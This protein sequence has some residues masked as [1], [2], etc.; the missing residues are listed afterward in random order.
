MELK[1]K[2]VGCLYRVSTKKQV[3]IEDDIPMQRNACM[4]FIKKREDWK[5]N[6]E[7]VEP[8][9]SG[10]HKGLNE[11]KVLQEVIKDVGE[12]NIDVLLV[13][14]FDRLGRKDDETPFLLKRIVE[15]GVEVWSVCEGQQT[16]ENSSDNLM[17][18]IRFWGASTESKKTAARVDSGRNY[19]TKMG[20]FT[21]G[22]VPYGYKLVPTGELDRK[23]RM[24]NKFAKDE[25][26]SRVVQ[27]MYNKLIDENMTLNGIVAYLNNDRHLKTR[28]GNQ[29]NTSTVRG[30]LKNPIYKGYMSYGK[31][32]MKEVEKSRNIDI[33]KEDFLD[34]KKR[35]RAVPPEEWILA[36]KANTD[37]VIVSEERWQLAQ[38]ILARRYKGYTDNLRTVED[39]T[40]K[41]SLL[42]V[43]LL[44]CGYCHGR[45]SPAVS[46][47]K[48][49]KVDGT[50]SRSYTEFYKCNV[51]G[52]SKKMCPSKS[53][54]SKYKLESA[55]LQEV[56]SFLDRVEQ[57]DCSDEVMKNKKIL[58]GESQVEQDRLDFLKKELEEAQKNIERFKQAMYKAIIGEGEFDSKYIN[59]GLKIAE[60]KAVGI[61]R[62]MVQ[63][64]KSIQAKQL[65][66][67][68]YLKTIKMVPVWREVF[69]EAPLNIKKKL[70]SILIEKIV[71]TENEIDIHFKI[72]IDSFLNIPDIDSIQKKDIQQTDSETYRK[73]IEE[74]VNIKK[75][76]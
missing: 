2:R 41:S 53:Y 61:E 6:R 15:C 10:Y 59:E 76:V 66:M 31:T 54:I 7:Y 75:G 1:K 9:V 51:R 14:M 27:D 40:W 55:V 52:R 64:E 12:K 37:Y 57:I 17:N 13:F 39:R 45:I 28:K 29:W 71:I 24:I 58:V 43:G 63:L 65:A 34:V 67:D 19:G 46:S 18:I 11:R 38:E 60:D 72:D 33:T 68:E 44:E 3:N 47:Q 20:R 32:R 48:V 50:I 56:Y 69:E 35:Q 25:F 36:E 30:I 62:E 42:L 23:N 4:E 22:I 5:F 74:K 49:I 26:E 21:G 8:G 16:F 73:I 70:L